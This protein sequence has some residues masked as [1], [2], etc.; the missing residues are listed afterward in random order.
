MGEPRQKPIPVTSGERAKLEQQKQRYESATGEAGDWGKFL[1]TITLLGLGAAGVY[2]LVK[3][4]QRSP[5][6]V[7]VRCTK[8]SVTFVMALP[9]GTGRAVYTTCPNCGA[10][11]VVDLGASR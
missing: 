8:C 6:S 5:Q 11:L 9:E 7:D 3:A 1:G 2:A 10:E 4:T